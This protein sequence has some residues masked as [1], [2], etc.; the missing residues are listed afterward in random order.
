MFPYTL[1]IPP[2]YVYGE[3]STVGEGLGAFSLFYLFAG[4][5]LGL[6]LNAKHVACVHNMDASS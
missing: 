6:T 5:G 3:D 1:Q 4:L 2:P